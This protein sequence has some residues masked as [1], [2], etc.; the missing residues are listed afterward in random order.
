M[1]SDVQYL[2]A[3]DPTGEW[4]VVRGRQNEVEYS[5]DD[6]GDHLFITIRWAPLLPL[7]FFLPSCWEGFSPA[8]RGS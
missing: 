7:S 6:R 3:D 1:T 4:R 8:A 2:S 5:V